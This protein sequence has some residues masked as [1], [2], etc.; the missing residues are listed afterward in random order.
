MLQ[1][2]TEKEITTPEKGTP[3]RRD[4]GLGEKYE[5][6]WIAKRLTHKLR[7]PLGVI[8]TA[9]SQLEMS[10]GEPLDEDDVSFLT[11]IVAAADDLEGILGRFLLFTGAY[12]LCADRVS[13]NEIAGWEIESAKLVY[14]S[15]RVDVEY[16][17][18]SSPLEIYGD[19]QLLSAMIS[20]VIENAFEAVSEVENGKVSLRT[21]LLENR[22]GV[23][24]TD[25]GPGITV[26]N[27]A[28][29]LCPF[30]TTKPGK[31][32]IGLTIADYAARMHG[33]D[34]VVTS[35]EAGTVVKI[36]VTIGN[37]RRRSHAVDTD[38]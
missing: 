36:K 1:S 2:E 21:E 17:L 9:A 31:T 6:P 12:R 22:L 32:G 3:F 19:Y 29:V 15:D 4:P 11:S 20:N 37:E 23:T 25:N 10:A 38:C 35:C 24:V 7:N 5:L 14:G 27:T 33:G 30:V 8:T 34:L 18:D 16:S 28:T 26:Q 13:L